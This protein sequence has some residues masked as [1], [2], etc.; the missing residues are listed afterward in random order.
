MLHF[1]VSNVDDITVGS[2]FIILTDKQPNEERC[3][4]CEDKECHK[5][6]D[7]DAGLP[8]RRRLLFAGQEVD[9][10]VVAIASLMKEKKRAKQSQKTYKLVCQVLDTDYIYFDYSVN[11]N[12]TVSIESY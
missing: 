8:P 6:P 10:L 5:N 2:L 3:N 12:A 7:D 9:P 4:S 1:K 11:Y